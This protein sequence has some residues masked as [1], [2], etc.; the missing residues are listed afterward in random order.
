[1]FKHYFTI[2]MRHL[3]KT[4]LYSSINIVGLAVGLASCLLIML[5]VR[6]ELSYDAFW[7]NAETIYQVQQTFHKPEGDLVSVRVSGAAKA[8]IKEYFPQDIEYS[9][10]LTSFGST[11]KHG[12]RAF[13]DSV[14]WVDS[15]FYDIFSLELMS[16]DLESAISDN[17][18]LAISESFAKKYFGEAN[19]IGEIV[20][21]SSYFVDRDFRIVA[22]FKD[23][24]HNTSLAFQ[25]LANMDSINFSKYPLLSQWSSVFMHTYFT[26]KD[27][28]TIGSINTQLSD[29]IDKNYIPPE[30]YS[31]R[32]PSEMVTLSTLPLKDMH[33]KSKGLWPLKPSGS[34]ST[35]IILSSTAGLIL[36]IAS[37]N[38]VNLSTARSLQRAREVVLRKVLGAKRQQVVVQFLSES[39]LTALASLLLGMVLVELAL[40]VYSSFLDRPLALHYFDTLT[41]SFLLGSVAFIGLLAGLYPAWIISGFLP[42]QVLKA[43]KTTETS[44]SANFRKALVTLQ[45]SVSI[46]LIIATAV[47]YGQ[48]QYSTTRDTGFKKANVVSI[49]IR[50][51]KDHPK[52][53]T[54]RE[55]IS[56]FPGVVNLAY[57][58]TQPSSTHEMN[59]IVFIPD[60]PSVGMELGIQYIGADFLSTYEIPLLAGRN[61][62][63]EKSTDGMPSLPEDQ[64]SSPTSEGTVIINLSA[65]Y[66]LGYE[67][68]E[69]AIGQSF[70]TIIGGT[71]DRF[72]YGDVSIIGVIPDI[73]FRSLRQAVEPEMYA[74]WKGD[75]NGVLSLSF[76]GDSKA[77]IQ[78]VETLWKQ[79][80][81]DTP[82]VYHFVDDI[83]RQEFKQEQDLASILGLFS[84]LAIAIASLGLYALA[85]FTAERRTKEIGIRKV[86]GA[87]VMDIV[88]LLLWQFSKP[89]L[90]ALL[91]AWPLAAWVMLRWLGSFPYH[92]ESWLLFPLGLLA[93]T[94]AFAIAWVAVGGNTAKVAREKPIKS[95]RYE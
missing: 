49:Y 14:Q 91:I 89:V 59:T 20:N 69:K 5:F 26:L 17:S 39:T 37:I 47:V 64:G 2:A 58:T 24:P 79:L 90:L 27:G 10:R 77:L 93:G 84:L 62:S 63:R 82:F 11:I 40:P 6:D 50:N 72:I 85:A 76:N 95:L 21:V 57:S 35:V 67:S 60:K 31:H 16:G 3:L 9:A 38:F 54:L 71:P 74:L 23:L 28:A 32:W 29:L 56:Q 12:P 94:V 86:L 48:M 46:F 36:L 81:P 51:S 66:A 80:F 73:P 4:R 87:S 18:S 88:R 78:Q 42:T 19:P 45:F 22:V 53:Q 25:A 61:Y 15:E 7:P 33:L 52:Q 1:M 43:N 55:Q 65:V 70:R 75:W 68:P 34:L 13:N 30:G 41:I 44:R 92:L 83:M 8:A